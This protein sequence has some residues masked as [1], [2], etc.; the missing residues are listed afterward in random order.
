M[1]GWDHDGWELRYC[2][3]VDFGITVGVVRGSVGASAAGAGFVQEN[4][5]L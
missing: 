2:I 1:C 5:T 3:H 4:D